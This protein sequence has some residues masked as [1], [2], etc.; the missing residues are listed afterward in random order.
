MGVYEHPDKPENCWSTHLHRHI[1]R[2]CL[3][4]PRAGEQVSSATTRKGCRARARG[5]DQAVATAVH[6]YRGAPRRAFGSG[7][8]H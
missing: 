5:A 3:Q 6:V 4:K 8:D 1:P 7:E 2:P